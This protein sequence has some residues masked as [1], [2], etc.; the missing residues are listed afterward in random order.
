MSLSEDAA[1]IATELGLAS[2]TPPDYTGYRHDQQRPK[3]LL[4]ATSSKLAFERLGERN[5]PEEREAPV[6]NDGVQQGEKDTTAPNTVTRVPE[7]VECA[8]ATLETWIFISD[9]AD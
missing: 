3:A 4:A 9:G 7:I 5:A 8:E 6:E 2:R 1:A